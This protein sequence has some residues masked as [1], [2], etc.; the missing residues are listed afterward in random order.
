MFHWE[1]RGF[2]PMG[3][4]VHTA[5]FLALG[6]ALLCNAKTVFFKPGHTCLTLLPQILFFRKNS[7][8]LAK[9]F[10]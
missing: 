6:K 8:E 3:K 4:S 9:H 2:E 7:K 1:K 10:L 5:E